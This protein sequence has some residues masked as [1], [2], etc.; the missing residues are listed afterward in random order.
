[1]ALRPPV[2]GNAPQDYDASYMSRMLSELR[3]YFERS[4]TPHPMNA[5]T[6]NINIGTLPTQTSLANLSSGDVYVDTSAG[7]VLKIKP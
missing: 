2:L 3:S 4:N 6:L 7:N 1:M 5:S